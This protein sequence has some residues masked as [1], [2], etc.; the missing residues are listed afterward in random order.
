MPATD[1]DIPSDV[2]RF[3]AK[4]IDAT[5]QIEVL[6]LLA[7]QPERTWTAEEVHRVVMTNVGSASVRL[8][9][10]CT[11]GFLTATS[12]QPPAYQFAPKEPE[13][14]DI[15]RQL[16]PIYRQ[17]MHR[18]ISLIYSK[19]STVVRSFADAFRLRKD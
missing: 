1:G 17:Q 4:H 8:Q 5:D 2:Q 16:A 3:I 19:P 7:S 13:W 18:V 11:K 6:L 10:F 9:D 14:A 15:L 12:T